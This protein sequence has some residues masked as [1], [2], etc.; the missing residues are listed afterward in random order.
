MAPLQLSMVPDRDLLSTSDAMQLPPPQKLAL[1]NALVQIAPATSPGLT[2]N[3]APSRY[4]RQASGA[5]L[6]TANSNHRLRLAWLTLWDTDVED[7]DVV[8]ID[9][10]G[11]SR[12]VTLTKEPLTFAIPVPADGVVKVTGIRDGDGGGITVGLASGASKAVFPVMSIGQV[13]GLR[14]RVD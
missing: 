12:T 3:S 1:Q 11:Y 6:A 2:A 14:V 8:R 5:V 10:Q 13:L 4:V 7:K 9:S